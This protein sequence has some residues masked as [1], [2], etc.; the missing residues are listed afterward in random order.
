MQKVVHGNSSTATKIQQ[1][2]KISLTGAVTGSTSFDGSS[3]V[4]I[5]TIL[6]NIAVITGSMEIDGKTSGTDFNIKSTQIDF[7][8]GFTRDNC[9]VVAFGSK[10]ATTLGYSYENLNSDDSKNFVMLYSAGPKAIVL[11]GA[12]AASNKIIVY[13]SNYYETKITFYYKIVLLK[14]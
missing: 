2:K 3:D 11:G 4:T 12:N 10:S 14:I 1:A 9:V 13:G 5:N 6:N 8:S 7:P